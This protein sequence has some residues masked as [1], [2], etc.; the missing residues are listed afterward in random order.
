MSG[1]AE[2]LDQTLAKP[3]KVCCNQRRS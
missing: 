1:M 2:V 3:W